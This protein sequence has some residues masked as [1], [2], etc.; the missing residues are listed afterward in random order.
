MIV[1][2][3]ECR[4]EPTLERTHCVQFFLALDQCEATLMQRLHLFEQS[5][6]PRAS[7][8]FARLVFVAAT[9]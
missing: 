4:L 2:R 5:A 1:V 9:L 6:P 7:I 8:S 3:I